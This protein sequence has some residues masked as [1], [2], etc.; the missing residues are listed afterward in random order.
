MKELK[1]K[2]TLTEEMLGTAQSG[3]A[4]IRKGTAVSVIRQRHRQC[5]S[6]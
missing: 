1:A 4:M 5:A 3:R 2:V 6:Q